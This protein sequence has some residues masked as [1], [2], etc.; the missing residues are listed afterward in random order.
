MSEKKRTNAFGEKKTPKTA[1]P[2]AWMSIHKYIFDLHFYLSDLSV[3][4]NQPVRKLVL[5][6][7]GWTV[8]QFNLLTILN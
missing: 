4:K 8:C 7:G 6:V 5:A 1:F 3:V 2:P